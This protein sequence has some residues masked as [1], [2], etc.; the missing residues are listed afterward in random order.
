MQA[1]YDFENRHS[2]PGS[3]RAPQA[4]LLGFLI[5]TGLA[6][7]LWAVIVSAGWALLR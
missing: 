6:G 4:P 3:D 1:I 5:G 2:A 7:L